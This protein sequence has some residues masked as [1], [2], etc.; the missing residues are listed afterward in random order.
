MTGRPET[1]AFLGLG[2]NIG[3]PATTMAI[4][5]RTLD[6]T[7]GVSVERVSSLYR[8]PPWG[9][10]DQ[11]DFLN[12]VAEVRTGL[13]AR[14]LLDACLST[15]RALKRERRERWGPRLIDL[16][17]LLYGEERIAGD[18]LEIPHPRML[19][20]AFVLVPLAEIAPGLTLDGLT[21]RDH[22]SRLDTGGIDRV[23]NGTGWW[24]GTGAE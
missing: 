4:A 15:E 11:P 6:A 18:G 20:R 9:E 5:L 3:D 8:T 14:E 19:G 12:A 16:D 7:D 1:R 2:G 21:V 24:K 23:S 17:I 10:V 13:S 22:L